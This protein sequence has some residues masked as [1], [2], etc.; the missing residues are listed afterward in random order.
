MRNEKLSERGVA[1]VVGGVEKRHQRSARHGHDPELVGQFG[2]AHSSGLFV[3]HCVP[4]ILRSMNRYVIIELPLLTTTSNVI[5]CDN[6]RIL[7]ILVSIKHA[8]GHIGM[9]TRVHVL[10][11]H[12]TRCVHKLRA[13]QPML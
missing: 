8:P 11:M 2:R 5:A 12:A 4:S 1:A 3:R 6:K 13:M 7:D 10:H 9:L